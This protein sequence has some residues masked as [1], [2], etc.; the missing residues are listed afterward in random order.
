M[1]LLYIAIAIFICFLIG[2][3]F[4]PSAPKNVTEKDIDNLLLEGKDIQAI[5]WYRA[6]HGVGLREAK[7]AIEQKKCES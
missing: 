5:K 2:G 4:V 1:I 7:E 3:L 6:L